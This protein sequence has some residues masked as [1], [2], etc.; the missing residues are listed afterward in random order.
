MTD[1]IDLEHIRYRAQSILRSATCRKIR[2]KLD[3]VNIQ[4]YMYAYIGDAI[5]NRRIN[6]DLGGRSYDPDANLLRY[7]SVNEEPKAIVHEATHAAI[8]ATHAGMKLTK[9]THEAAA[10]LAESMYEMLSGREAAT[11]VSGLT[12]PVARLARAAIDFNESNKNATFA[13]PRYD[14]ENIK[15]ILMRSGNVGDYTTPKLQPGIGDGARPD[16]A[17]WLQGWWTVYDGNTYY[18][19]FANQSVTYTKL[20]PAGPSAPPPQSPGNTGKLKISAQAPHVTIYWDG[21]T[22]ERFT[23]AGGTSETDMNGWSSRYS[24]PNAMKGIS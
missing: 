21:G 1:A 3:T 14:T 4:T 17:K 10:Y 8:N 6:V 19:Y 7:D 5:V 2:F 20:K 16:S 9:A 11:D 13:C 24:P 15:S 18:Y 23:R 22:E 12:G